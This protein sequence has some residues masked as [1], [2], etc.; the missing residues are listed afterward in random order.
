MLGFLIGTICLIGL[1]KVLR[2][3]HGGRYGM[4]GYGPGGY[5]PPG[6]GPCGHG[7]RWGGGCDADGWEGEGPYRSHGG[8]WGGL[9]GRGRG[10]GG[11][12]SMWLRWV[13]Q[14]VDATPA[15]EKVIAAAAQEIGEAIGK[16]RDEVRKSREDIGK[17]MRSEAF[18]EVLFGELFARHDSAMEA[19][20]KATV[21]A[22][23]K[24]HEA[25]D[26]RQRARLAELIESG[27]R[28]FRSWAGRSYEI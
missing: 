1:V 7:S 24:V 25:L 16:S 12:P 14:H 8:G 17:A 20:R 5:G 27:P 10:W 2:R 9:R 26:E 22:L 28:F 4:C 21:G 15:Q 19:L 11:G 3:G 18:D 13:M 23:A 6:Y